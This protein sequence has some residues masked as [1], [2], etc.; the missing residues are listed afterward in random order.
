MLNCLLNL[1]ACC[2]DD[3]NEIPLKVIASFSA[4]RFALNSIPLIVLHRLVR[5]V[6]WSM[7][8]N[9][10]SISG[11]YA[12]RCV[13]ECLYSVLEVQTRWGLFCRG[14]LVWSSRPVSL[15]VQDPCGVFVVQ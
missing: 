3:K 6:F 5:F 10:I 4:V 7:F 1:A 9:K 13:S 2:L 11:V 8:S 15:L 14:R 12:H